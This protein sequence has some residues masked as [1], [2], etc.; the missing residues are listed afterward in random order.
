[1]LA[2]AGQGVA[3]GLA[4]VLART[5]SVDGFAIYAVA[6]AAFILMVTLVLQGFDKY[7]LQLLPALI[8]RADWGRARAY[9]A[10]GTR[11]TLTTALVVGGVVG[12]WAWSLSGWERD[13]RLAV[14]VCC[15]ALPAGALAHF[16]H[17][18]LAALGRAFV[19]AAVFRMAVP[20]MALVFV[21]ALALPP[22]VP[23]SA[24][25]AVGCW[26]VAWVV[27]LGVMV[28]T[29]RRSA[30]PGIFQ[31]TP[32]RESSA[33]TRAA[34]PFWIYRMALAALAHMGIIGLNLL[35]PAAGAVGAFA[36]A[37][38]TAGLA[39]VIVT[40]TN[41]VY[42]RQLSVLL[43]RRDFAAI[44]T[45]RRKRL[46]WIAMPITVYLVGVFVFADELLALFRPEFVAEGVVALR[47]LS[48]A[49]AFTMLFALAPTYLKFRRQNHTLYQ[50]VAVA[51]VVQGVLLVLLVPRLGAAGAAV[52]YA[53][54]MGG[55]YGHMAR[56]A[57][58]ELKSMQAL[59]HGQ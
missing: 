39:Q 9:L 58:R 3:Y 44:H 28:R 36:A 47:I 1:M 55:L 16:A 48:V 10:L 35:Q 56:L 34:R 12:V 7:A 42:A 43:E 14:V 41:R 59:Q 50:S 45:L 29:I 19:A 31:T 57:H 52:A 51:A 2:V 38:G 40:A 46:Q 15:I 13:M 23:V 27:A 26:G 49:V 17:E 4:V 21:V 20:G 6:S 18:V 32:V 30:P 54:S 37:M 53:M 8:D 33:W 24:A 11:R 22:A 5:L 25:A